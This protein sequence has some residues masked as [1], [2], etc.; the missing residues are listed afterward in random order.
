MLSCEL[1]LFLLSVLNFSNLIFLGLIVLSSGDKIVLSFLP[2]LSDD[3][4]SGLKQPAS[5]LFVDIE[6]VNL[7]SRLEDLYFSILDCN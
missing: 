7:F 1:S 5:S 2:I 4:T 3:S 6:L